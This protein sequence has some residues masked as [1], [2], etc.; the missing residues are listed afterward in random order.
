M[1]PESGT[2]ERTS[3]CGLV[4]R[5]RG[6]A[7]HLPQTCGSRR[8]RGHGLAEC[9]VEGEQLTAVQG[10]S[11]AECGSEGCHV[12]ITRGSL[13]VSVDVESTRDLGFLSWALDGL[14]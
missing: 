5:P 14:L 9:G 11:L 4:A 12:G 10:R 1:Q 8:R 2:G 6:G 7:G 13:G 3:S